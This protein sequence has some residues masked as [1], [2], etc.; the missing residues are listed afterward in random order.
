MYMLG[1]ANPGLL[2]TAK[3]TLWGAVIGAAIV[4]FAYLFISTLVGFLKV[5]GLGGFSSGAISCPAA[6]TS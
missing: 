6:P 3:K 5:T 1:G 4:L 2:E